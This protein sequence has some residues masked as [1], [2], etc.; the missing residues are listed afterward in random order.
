MPATA[1]MMVQ[2]PLWVALLLSLCTCKSLRSESDLMHLEGDVKVK[3]PSFFWHKISSPKEL[4]NFVKK[5]D[6]AGLPR[7]P[8][9]SLITKR[10]QKIVDDLDA[11]ARSLKPDELAGIPK[12]QIYIAVDTTFQAYASS[13]PICIKQKV[14]RKGTAK[15]LDAEAASPSRPSRTPAG[16]SNDERSQRRS[17]PVA[18]KKLAF[19][20]PKTGI[21]AIEGSRDKAP[22]CVTYEASDVAWDP[23]AFV[24]LWN[25]QSTIAEDK[26]CPIAYEGG[27]IVVNVSDDCPFILR[28]PSYNLIYLHTQSNMITISTKTLKILDEKSIV[29]TL[30]HEMIH[31]YRAH[32]VSLLSFEPYFFEQNASN[33]LIKPVET[34]AHKAIVSGLSL[35]ANLKS[36]KQ[37]GGVTIEP[38]LV[39]LVYKLLDVVIVPFC[40]EL[41][42]CKEEIEA[43]EKI[44]K[45]ENSRNALFG[46]RGTLEFTPEGL[47]LYHEFEELA[48]KLMDAMDINSLPQEKKNLIIKLIP[49]DLAPF[50]DIP[51]ANSLREWIEGSGKVIRANIPQLKLLY[52]DARTLS[53]GY[54]TIEEEADEGGLEI[55]ARSGLSLKDAERNRWKLFEQQ[56]LSK[57]LPDDLDVSYGDCKKLYDNGWRSSSGEGISGVLLGS[58]MDSHHGICYRLYNIQR[59]WQAHNYDRSDLKKWP[60]VFDITRWQ[61]ALKDM[62][63]QV[64]K[65]SRA[66]ARADPNQT[67]P[68]QAPAEPS[69]LDVALSADIGRKL[70][71]SL[72]NRLRQGR[73]QLRS[74]SCDMSPT[75][76]LR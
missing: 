74:P 23:Q 58:L 11:I 71:K 39:P 67:A 75:S 62:D 3:A 41:Q 16:N 45:N 44:K 72:V 21:T 19:I 7:L 30:A 46:A 68:R 50:M 33:E 69:D 35:I 28:D 40:T 18:E 63:E 2:A 56:E 49:D 48:F 15:W 27:S 9:D 59:E 4:D 42:R 14:T 22:D 1:S 51:E 32:T 47:A 36:V 54:Y 61:E 53:L 76:R 26:E 25:R 34:K 52:E 38:L 64:L 73:M 65:V 31:Y 5:G 55:L 24:D 13:V 43:L 8:P 10:V 17:D 29:M 6:V 37:P 70:P 20:K 60:L 57:I 66:P 12:P